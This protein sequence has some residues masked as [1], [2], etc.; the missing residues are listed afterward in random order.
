LRVAS[1][2]HASSS[3]R[4][5]ATRRASPHQRLGTRGVAVGESDGET[6]EQRIDRARL[7]RYCRRA[8]RRRRHGADAA[9]E[10]AR[11]A[12]GAQRLEI[13]LARELPVER[14]QRPSRAEEQRHGIVAPSE[15]E[16]DLAVEPLAHRAIELAERPFG[17]RGQQRQGLLRRSRQLL[18]A[19]R[20]ERAPGA[21]RGVGGE[22][23]G[24]AEERGRR[25]ESSARLRSPG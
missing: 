7:P 9:A 19:G 18:G 3:N 16:R 20:L 2:D 13:G 4:S 12:R 25:R 14:L 6:V 17:R 15:V 10:A 22:F 24:A 21:Q 23:C 5:G 8:T 11:D 1:A